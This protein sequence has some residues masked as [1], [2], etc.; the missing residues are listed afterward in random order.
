[1]HSNS[2]F[3]SVTI[4]VFLSLWNHIEAATYSASTNLAST[5]SQ[6]TTSSTISSSQS[7]TLGISFHSSIPFNSTSSG[8]QT[9]SSAATPKTSTGPSPTYSGFANTTASQTAAWYTI[10]SSP[11]ST[12]TDGTPTPEPAILVPA[13]PPQLDPHDPVVLQPNASVSLFYQQPSLSN[14]SGNSSK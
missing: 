13:T 1:M 6:N 2:F 11:I 5:V 14:A 8:V 9:N 4:F 12:G 3:H 7:T 10:K